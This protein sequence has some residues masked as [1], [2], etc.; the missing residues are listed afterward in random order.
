MSHPLDLNWKKFGTSLLNVSSDGIAMFDTALQAVIS[1]EIARKALDIYPGSLLNATLP[2]LESAAQ[3]VLLEKAEKIETEIQKKERSYSAMVS[4]ICHGG[5]FIGILI[6]FKDTTAFSKVTHRMQA[7]QELSIELDTIIESSND[8]LFIC[9][10]NGTVLRCNPASER[11]TGIDAKEVVGRNVLELVQRGKIDRSVT[12]EV[13]K[14]GKKYPSSRRPKP[15]NSSFSP[16]VPYL[17]RTGGCSGW[18]SMNGIS[19]RLP[20]CRSS[21]R[22]RWR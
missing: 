8:G 2:D 15:A 13:I 10:G 1:N 16:A 3:D 6:L 21:W 5:T 18:W 19:Q 12:L 7:F 22:R 9:D 14:K 17:T 11:L 4:P 20:I